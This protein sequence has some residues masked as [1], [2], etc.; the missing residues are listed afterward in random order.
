MNK[1][2]DILPSGYH[3]RYLDEVDSTNNEAQRLASRSMDLPL[4]ILAD[5][6]REGRGRLGRQW[7]SYKGNLTATL[8]FIPSCKVTEIG[9]LGFV[10]GLAVYDTIV[11]LFGIIDI[12]LKWPNDILYENAKLAGI[13]LETVGKTEENQYKIAIGIGINLAHYPMNESYSSISLKAMTGLD[14]SPLTALHHLSNNVKK[15]LIIW[16][17][18]GFDSLRTLWLTRAYSLGKKI[19]IN[20]QNKVLEGIFDTIDEYGQ[21][22][23][24][25]HNG[26]IHLIA[27]GDIYFSTEMAHL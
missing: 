27:A 26:Q 9:Q 16:E 22:V 3:F 20:F 11:E 21:L 14:V 1:Y 23:L 25:N 7:V 24:K 15:W 8:L 19:K 18:S 13:L 10:A 12:K 17:K 5:K 2:Q 6:Q 4:W